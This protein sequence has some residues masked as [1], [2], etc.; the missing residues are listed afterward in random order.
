MFPSRIR[1]VISFNYSPLAACRMDALRFGTEWISLPRAI[2][3]WIAAVIQITVSIA[4]RPKMDT[5]AYTKAFRSL[6]KRQW[7]G[8]MAIVL[9]MEHRVMRQ[10][11]DRTPSTYPV[12]CHLWFQTYFIGSFEFPGAIYIVNIK[13]WRTGCSSIHRAAEVYRRVWPMYQRSLDS[14]AIAA[15]TI[16]DRVASDIRI[17]PCKSLNRLRHPFKF[18]VSISIKWI[19]HFENDSGYQLILYI[20]ETVFITKLIE[21]NFIQLRVKMIPFSY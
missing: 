19:C 6:S 1:V 11:A 21:L 14:N 16:G 3:E 7:C 20:D 12:G 15:A 13:W 17:G 5:A 8:T 2:T 10:P 4:I 18:W 9:T